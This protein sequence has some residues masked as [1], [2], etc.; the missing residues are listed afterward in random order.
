MTTDNEQ[1]AEPVVDKVLAIYA[2]MLAVA[3]TTKG[4][5]GEW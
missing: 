1:Q 5:G 3:P 4:T 2:A